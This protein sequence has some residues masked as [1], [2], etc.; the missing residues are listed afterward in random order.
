MTRDP[1]I[2]APGRVPGRRNRHRPDAD[3]APRLRH[4]ETR[5]RP[6]LRRGPGHRA[7][8]PRPPGRRH[9]GH[10]VPRRG[11]RPVRRPGR[12]MVV[13]AGPD[14][15]DVQLRPRHPV[16]RDLARP[17]P[18]RAPGPGRDRR[19]VPRPALPRR[20]GLRR[21]LGREPAGGQQHGPAPGRRGRGRRLRHRA[22]GRPQERTA[23]RR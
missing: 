16:V 23:P 8:G 9:P 6:G 3:Q 5:P 2:A 7:P 21:L 11:R 1:R 19:S 14:R 22:H 15:R 18:R 13:D 10:R 20:R 12:W 4:R 17:A